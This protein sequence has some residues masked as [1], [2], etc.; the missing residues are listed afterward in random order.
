ML[1]RFEV[2]ASHDKKCQGKIPLLWFSPIIY[3]ILFVT[4]VASERA[5]KVS[6]WFTKSRAFTRL[7]DWAY[8]VCDKGKTNHISSEQLYSGLLLVHLNLAKYFGSAA[9]MVRTV[10]VTSSIARGRLRSSFSSVSFWCP[11]FSV[12]SFAGRR[13]GFV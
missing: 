6:N 13:A 1:G 11:T 10:L 12:A 2:R 9:C 4:T 3:C 8:G 5:A 7:V